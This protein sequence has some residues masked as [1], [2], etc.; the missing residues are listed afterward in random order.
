[1]TGRPWYRAALL[2]LLACTLGGMAIWGGTMTYDPAM[3]NYP[4]QDDIAPDPTAYVGER[5]ALGGTVIETDPVVIEVEY[6]RGTFALTL[7]DVEEPLTPG[8]EVSVF[9]TLTEPSTLEVERM[10]VRWPWEAIYM[11]AVSLLGAIWVAIRMARHFEF[12]RE[13]WV[14]MPRGDE[15]G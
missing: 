9:G 12:D 14:A 10:F 6:Q 8:Q 15:H 4:D 5:V 3:N 7:T 1:M 11:Y 13:R 2:I